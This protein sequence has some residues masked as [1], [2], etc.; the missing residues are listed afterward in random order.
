MGGVLWAEDWFEKCLLTIYDATWIQEQIKRRY[1]PFDIF[2]KTTDKHY[3]PEIHVHEDYLKYSEYEIKA[4]GGTETIDPKN[5][6]QWV[7]TV[8]Y[9]PRPTTYVLRPIYT[10]LPV[11]SPLR[12]IL[13]Q[14]THEYRSQL[15]SSAEEYIDELK[16][17]ADS[18]SS[19]YSLTPILPPPELKNKACK[20]DFSMLWRIAFR[21][22]YTTGQ[23]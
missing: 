12:Q 14:A 4:F 6:A 5:W 21:N 15:D 13:K 9:R 11:N 16:S 3:T 19:K 23:K 22:S 18:P 20:C 17:I 10:L 2:T 1:D 7:P 8:K